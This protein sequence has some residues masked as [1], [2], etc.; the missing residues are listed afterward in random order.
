MGFSIAAANFRNKFPERKS[1]DPSFMDKMDKVIYN[2]WFVIGSALLMFLIIAN[3]RSDTGASSYNSPI[4]QSEYALHFNSKYSS[5]A[6]LVK[7]RLHDP[8]SFEFE[9]SDYTDNKDGTLAII[10]TYRAKNGFGAVRTQRASAELDL[11]NKVFRKLIVEL[12]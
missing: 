2:K 9:K 7:E 1:T 11:N 3:L 4:S 6:D 5:L 12:D 8:K 10:M